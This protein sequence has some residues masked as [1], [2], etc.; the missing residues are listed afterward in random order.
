VRQ[1]CIRW[2]LRCFLA[3]SLGLGGCGGAPPGSGA[4]SRSGAPPLSVL[5]VTLDT[6]RADH[7]GAYGS[8]RGATPHLDALAARGILFERAYAVA[9]MTLPAHA[10]LLTARLPTRTGLRWNGEQ[11]LADAPAQMPTLAERFRAG[12]YA[13]AAFVSA[14]VLHR[15][16][17]LDRGFDRYDDAVA[18]TAEA[19][20]T[21][22]EPSIWKAERPAQET[23]DRALAWLAEQPAERPV[24]LWVHLFE[25]HDPYLPPEPFATR[26]RDHPYSGEV[27]AADDAVGRLL[28]SARFRPG[29]RAVVSVIGDHGESLGE[30]GEATH[31][32]LLNE[33]ALR[34]PWILAAPDIAP[35]RHASA[36]SQVDVAPTLLALAE[37]AP[38]AKASELDGVDLT[39]ELRGEGGARAR[40][41]YAESLYANHLYGWAP[42]ASTRRGNFKWILGKR[43]ELFDFVADPG[44]RRDL[45]ATSPAEAGALARALE[46][47]RAGEATPADVAS[48]DVDSTLAANLRSLGYLSGPGAGGQGASTAATSASDDPRDRIALHEQL[49]AIDAQWHRGDIAGAEQALDAVFAADPGNRLVQRVI[50]Q[51]LR[52]AIARYA[53]TGSDRSTGSN[54]SN[55]SE[56]ADSAP[57]VSLRLQVRLA[58]I[59][60]LAGRSDEARDQLELAAASTATGA[61]AFEARAIAHRNLANLAL[62]ER[63]FEDAERHARAATTLL[64]G[65]AAARNTLAIALDD[66]GRVVEAEAAY[67]QALALDPALYRSELNL[68]LLLAGQAGRGAD[69]AGHLHRYLAMAPPGDPRAAEARALL[70]TLPAGSGGGA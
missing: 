15:A 52:A 26:F 43:G 62:G 54:P 59:L 23:V 2:F 44:E 68:A 28:E 7:L 65:D 53:A 13:T 38:L 61:A 57:D 1:S 33:A 21:G 3:T 40:T 58:Q 18:D 39:T 64:P 17:G 4:P 31:G 55:S 22:G 49:R 37:Q 69:A 29:A 63:R 67:R 27:A 56:P 45:A 32:I 24:F 6:T 36:V 42:L 14:A 8:P 51:Q 35:R 10:S 70:A 9:P 34:V 16:F 60:A 20:G 46:E 11:K 12:R 5:L 66:L 30:H 48:A 25:P 47:F 41:L 19:A 50:E